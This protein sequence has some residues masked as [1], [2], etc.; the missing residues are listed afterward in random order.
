MKAD[1]ITIGDEILIGQIVDTNSVFIA[2]EFDKNGIYVRRI[3]S[4]P[5]LEMDIRNTLD[6]SLQHSDIIILTGGLGPTNDDITKNTLTKYF[7]GNPILNE[8]VLAKITEFF[9]YRGIEVSERNKKQAEVP[10][11]CI[12]L[13]NHSGTAPGMVFH[14]DGKV[15]VSLPGVPFEMKELV[16]D[17]VIPYLQKEFKLPVRYHKT[18][19]TIGIGESAL[20]DMIKDWEDQLSPV[21]GLA[22]L[23]S[24]GM[25]K[26]RLSITGTKRT[27]LIKIFNKE[28]DSLTSLIGEDFIYGFDDD[29]LEKIT[30]RMLLENGYSASTAESCTGGYIAHLITSVP[31]SS[32]YFKGSVIAYANEIK[33]SVIDV[34]K[35]LIKKYGA[36]S[37]E[38]AEAMAKGIQNLLK[39]DISIATTGIFGPEG[40]SS[41]KPVGT[42]WISIALPDKI[43]TENFLFGD[44]RG[45]NI[46]KAS[47]TALNMLR[48]EIRTLNENIE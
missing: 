17:Q 8:A 6:D 26:L 13:P 9:K 19:L 46:T 5:D 4:V 11:N 42:T 27:E 35:S 16:V 28:L 44:H 23:P 21:F 34:P 38:V 22:Y 45:R 25:V 36:V 2:S 1:I 12:V 32:F 10:D 20:A 40:G 39:T 30:G 48:N 14:K 24:P 7:G 33:S 3:Y 43:V 41:E 31:G 37:K 15:I 29:T 18:V 47:L